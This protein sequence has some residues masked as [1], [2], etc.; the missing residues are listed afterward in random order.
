VEDRLLSFGLQRRKQEVSGFG[1]SRSA[2]S[3][4]RFVFTEQSVGV[5]RTPRTKTTNRA[6]CGRGIA[7]L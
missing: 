1:H 3:W 2:F 7:S 4:S 6:T 5:I